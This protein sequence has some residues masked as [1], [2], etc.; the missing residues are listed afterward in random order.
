[1]RGAL[2][3]PW[4]CPNIRSKTWTGNAGTS[5][6]QKTERKIVMGCSCVICKACCRV[7]AATRHAVVFLPLQGMLSCSCPYKACCHVPAPTRHAVM[8]LPL[9]GMLSCSCPYKA[10][11]LVPAPTLTMLQTSGVPRNFFWRGFYTRNFFPGGVQQIQLRTEGR[12]NG[13]LGA[14]TPWSGV[15]L[16]LQMNETHILIRLLWMYIPRNWEFGSA[17]A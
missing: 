17:L 15:P 6:L 5:T 13:D 4:S 12:Q 9:Q 10:C 1:M 2:E 14:V 16:N 11:C 8:F 3:F 7:P